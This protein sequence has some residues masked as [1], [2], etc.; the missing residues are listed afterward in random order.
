VLSQADV[1]LLLGLFQRAVS[2]DLNLPCICNRD[3]RL[4]YP[5]LQF[6][7]R[8]ILAGLSEVIAELRGALEPL[9]IASWLTAPQRSLCGRRPV[10]LLRSGSA[11]DAAAVLAAARRLGLAAG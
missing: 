6:D 10:D 8:R 9:T 11:E 7:G 4:A 5:V 3:G 1:A 2:K